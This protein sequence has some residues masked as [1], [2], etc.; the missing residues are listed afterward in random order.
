MAVFKSKTEPPKR[1]D[2]VLSVNKGKNESQ[3][4]N[5]D[6]KCFHCLRV[7]HIAPQCPNKRT[8]ITHVDGEVETESEGDDD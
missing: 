8:M 3:T 4:H 2:E 7:G 5:R 1:R 6:I